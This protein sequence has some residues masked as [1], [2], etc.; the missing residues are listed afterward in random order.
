MKKHQVSDIVDKMLTYPEDTRLAIFTKIIL[1]DNR[2][3]NEQLEIL[4]KEGFSRVE[5][6][7]K[8][9]RIE[10]MLK[11]KEKYTVDRLLLLIDRLTCDK[12]AANISRFSES[13]ETAFYEGEG[14]CIVRF[15]IGDKIESFDFSRH[16]EA[17]GIQFQEPTDLMFSFNSP[18]GACPVCEGFGRV[19]GIDEDLVVPNK[20]LSVYEDAVMCWRGGKNERMENGV[21]PCRR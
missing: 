21:Y 13:I 5:F 3:L 19:M 14:D 11:S 9:E 10:D 20:G 12:D 4:Q 7:G 6:D 15:Y 17:D 16:F 18:V 1:R 2:T 8:V